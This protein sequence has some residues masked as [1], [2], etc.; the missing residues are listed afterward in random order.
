MKF[1]TVIRAEEEENV[2]T[3]STINR[4]NSNIFG[5]INY[6]LSEYI[7]LNYDFSID[8]DFSTF[9]YNSLDAEFT[10]NNF[11]STIKFLEE[12]GEIGNAHII[13]NTFEYNLDDQNTL[14]FATRR[15]KEINLTEYYDL[16]Y[17]YK[18]DCLTAGIE[19]K[20]K[21]YRNADIKPTEEIFF[22]VTIVPL[23]TFS[24][25]PLVPKSILNEDFKNMFKWK[26]F[27]T[28]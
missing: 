1:A 15:N 17:Q 6:S 27:F 14:K 3:A 11:S 19:F 2:P 8:N 18:N 4:K 26:N 23:G 21:F 10:Y 20:K 12:N 13:A 16:M 22:S 5:Q 7:S 28:Q 25:E 9:E 24:P